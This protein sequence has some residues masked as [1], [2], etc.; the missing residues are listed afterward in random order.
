MSVLT[1]LAGP[2]SKTRASTFMTEKTEKP[3][4][5]GKD[6]THVAMEAQEYGPVRVGAA[7]NSTADSNDPAD[8]A[9]VPAQVNGT[10]DGPVRKAPPRVRKPSPLHVIVLPPDLG[11][12][13]RD[14]VRRVG[15]ERQ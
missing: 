2:E 6:A 11:A 3:R 10:P 5:S 8:K 7:D 15:V 12:D 1:A 9:Q 13:I 14:C 4:I